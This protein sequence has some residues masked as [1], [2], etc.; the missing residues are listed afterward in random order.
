MKRKGIIN[1]FEYVIKDEDLN[2]KDKPFVIP[3][4]KSDKKEFYDSNIFYKLK[5][6]GNPLALGLKKIDFIFINA[7]SSI[8]KDNQVVELWRYLACL[9]EERNISDQASRIVA[10]Y[11]SLHYTLFYH[12]L[13]LQIFD[14]FNNPAIFE[15]LGAFKN[16][17]E[18]LLKEP[19]I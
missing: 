19:R 17:I 3:L 4:D 13:L 1:H 16:E 18:V 7:C 15:A 14:P 2:K 12:H 11:Y 9:F 6:Y 5:N 8:N 10:N